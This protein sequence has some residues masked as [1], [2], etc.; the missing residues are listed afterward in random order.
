MRALYITLSLLLA[1]PVLAKPV[2]TPLDW[3][4]EGTRFSG[5]VIYDD[6]SDAIRP[7]LAMVPNWM[8]INDS[9]IEKAK[10][11]AGDEFVVLLVDMYGVD[12]RPTDFKSASAAAGAVYADPAQM[13]GRIAQAVEVLRAQFGKAPLDIDRVG[14]IGFCFGGSTVLELARSGATVSGVVSFHGGLKTSMPAG[15]GDIHT[16]LLILNGAAD[17]N[18]SAEDIAALTTEMDAAGAD[19]ELVNFPGA[20]HCFAEADANSPPN[21]LYDAPSAK[22]AYELMHEFFGKQ[23]KQAEGE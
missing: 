19:W 15:V 23:F 12:V 2:V 20:H 1:G 3:N 10:V 21:C 5:Y 4:Y 17:T 6:A 22:R 14:A 16:P 11:I 8:G 18:V 7:G 9:A 13:R